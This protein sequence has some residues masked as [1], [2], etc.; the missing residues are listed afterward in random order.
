MDTLAN[1]ISAG[2]SPTNNQGFW[3]W[4]GLR[5]GTSSQ[6]GSTI[7]QWASGNYY[8]TSSQVTWGTNASDTFYM[9]AV[10]FEL[11]STATPFVYESSGDQLA[12]CQR[13]FQGPITSYPA[14]YGS[15]VIGNIFYAVAMSKTPTAVIINNSGALAFS[16][17]SS[18]TG[19]YVYK[20]SNTTSSIKFTVEAELD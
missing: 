16:A 5:L 15:G 7:N 17:N 18:T 12:K 2:G 14:T 11:G 3:I 1:Y 10:K 20:G 9:G 19:G 8:G 13:Y 6:Q 4:F